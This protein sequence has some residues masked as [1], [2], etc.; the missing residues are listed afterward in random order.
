MICEL[1]GNDD[2]LCQWMPGGMVTCRVCNEDHPLHVVT[3][4]EQ[5]ASMAFFKRLSKMPRSSD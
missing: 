4:E 5:A 1:C 2:P 3:A